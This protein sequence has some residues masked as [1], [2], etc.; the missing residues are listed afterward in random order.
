MNDAKVEAEDRDAWRKLPVGFSVCK[1]MFR[2]LSGFRGYPRGAGEDTFIKAFQYAI[3]SVDHGRAV[4]ASFTGTMPTIQ[5]IRDSAFALRSQFQ[6]LEDMRAKWEE[7]Y[8]KPQ[9]VV[10]DV[11]NRP[12][13]R[14]EDVLW[15]EIL[16]RP[17]FKGPDGRA[18]LQKTSWTKLAVIAREL[19]FTE[20]ARAWGG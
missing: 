14:A 18:K 16:K 5:E 7:E 19:G 12:A 2:E 8:G 1:A 15:R 20:H 17:E 13:E 9:P 6:P 11:T 10:L 4:L 3:V